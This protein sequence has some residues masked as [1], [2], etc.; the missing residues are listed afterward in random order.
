MMKDLSDEEYAR[1]EKKWTETTPKVGPNGSGYF[2][3]RKAA[4]A[5]TVTIDS[6]SA[7]YLNA[8][9]MA[10]HKTPAEIIGEMVYE[11]IAAAL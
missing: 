9:A 11:R 2:S 6:F 1:L 8:K 7:N 4:A 10:D 5:H 3:Q